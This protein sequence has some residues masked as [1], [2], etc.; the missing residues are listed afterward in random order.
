MENINPRSS[1]VPRCRSSKSINGKQWDTTFY[2]LPWSIAKD[3]VEDT[4]LKLT[5]QLNERLNEL[6]A[7]DVV[8]LQKTWYPEVPFYEALPKIRQKLEASDYPLSQIMKQVLREAHLSLHLSEYQSLITEHEA[9]LKHKAN[10]R[11]QLDQWR[12]EML[13]EPEPEP[14]P[15][16]MEPVIVKQKKSLWKNLIRFFQRLKIKIILT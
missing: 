4:Y 3:Q 10:A 12:E 1:Y 2:D 14:E 13:Y 11:I 15:V 16:A 5:E 6:Y 9:W 7:D 8:L